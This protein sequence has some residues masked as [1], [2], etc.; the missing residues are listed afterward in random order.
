MKYESIA[1]IY[2]ANRK[3]RNQLVDFA[4]GVSQ[5]EASTLPI[6]EKWTIEQIFEHLALVGNGASRICSRLLTG[7]K[8]DNIP[9]GG[10]FALSPEFGERSAVIAVTKV[11]AP[12]RVQPTGNVSIGEALEQLAATET[13]FDAMRADMESY[14]LGGHTFPHPFFGE[15]TAGEWM[16]VAGLHEKRHLSQMESLLSAIRQ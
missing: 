11:E 15:M 3:I 1:D 9:S 13:A 7:A 14:E 4:R 5:D 10:I 12:D 6:G 2:S 16:V 8:A